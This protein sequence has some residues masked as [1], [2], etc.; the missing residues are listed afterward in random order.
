MKSK[1]KNANYVIDNLSI[2][3]LFY[4][5]I[6]LF[7]FNYISVEKYFSN[8]TTP[9]ALSKYNLKSFYLCLQNRGQLF[10]VFSGDYRCHQSSLYF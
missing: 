2:L 5:H 4:A 6:S 1:Y 10:P 7:H 8:L 3:M 9:V